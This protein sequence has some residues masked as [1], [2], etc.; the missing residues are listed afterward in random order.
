MLMYYRNPDKGNENFVAEVLG[1][2][3]DPLLVGNSFAVSVYG[4]LFI[5]VLGRTI[6][7]AGFPFKGAW[8]RLLS[9]A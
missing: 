7:V 9:G 2:I 4:L 1:V 3:P 6:G 5:S 8:N